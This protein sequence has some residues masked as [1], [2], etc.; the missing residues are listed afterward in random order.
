MRY[1]ASFRRRTGSRRILRTGT[2]ARPEGVNDRQFR[3]D[4][5]VDYNRRNKRVERIDTSLES[6]KEWLLRKDPE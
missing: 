1:L 3:I 6:L 2:H 5:I 4:L